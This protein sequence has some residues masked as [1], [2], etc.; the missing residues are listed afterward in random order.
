[1]TNLNRTCVDYPLFVL[2]TLRNGILSDDCLSGTSMSGDE[3]T[4]ISLNSMH[5][6]LL[7]RIESELVFACWFS[8]WYMVGDRCIRVARRN[9]NLVADLRKQ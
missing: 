3:D 7:E 2:E 9:S 8:W 6:N 5:S 4:L 1:M